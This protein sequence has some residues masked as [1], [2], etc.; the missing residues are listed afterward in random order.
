MTRSRAMRLR[1]R[2]R[3]RAALITALASALA[4]CWSPTPPTPGGS[5]RFAVFGDGPY[6]PQENG[7]ARRVIEALN[8]RPLEFVIHLGANETGVFYCV[9][10]SFI[11]AEIVNYAARIV[12]YRRGV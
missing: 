9:F 7:R 11:L 6:Y 8:A 3:L 10:L 12:Y 1:S 4:G 5:F 2:L